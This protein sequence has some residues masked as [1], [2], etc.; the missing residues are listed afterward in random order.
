MDKLIVYKNRTNRVNVDLGYDVSGDTL[1]SQIRTTSGTL[2]ASW[3]VTFD[4]DGSDG[5][6]ILVL[7]DSV[8]ASVAYKT[9]LMDILRVSVGERY[10]VFDQPLEVEF[11]D[12]VTELP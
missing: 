8:T 11:R 5:K 3:T 9:G 4:S 7:D 12:T 10:A 6:I 1:Y 2:I